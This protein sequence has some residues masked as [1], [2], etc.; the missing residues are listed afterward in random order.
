MRRFEYRVLCHVGWYSLLKVLKLSGE[1]GWELV[2]THE[3]HN[4]SSV[5]DTDYTLIF[6][7]ELPSFPGDPDKTK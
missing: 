3:T 1:E 4:G 2:S 7:R 6:K 5:F